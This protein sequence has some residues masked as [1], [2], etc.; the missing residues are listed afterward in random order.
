[1]ALTGDPTQADDLVQETL[2]RILTYIE[3]NTKIRDLRAYMFTVL[4]NVRLNQLAKSQR[5]G[6]A[7]SLSDT[8]LQI[9]GPASQEVHIECRDLAE[10][11]TQIPEEQRQ[12]VL[13][14][15]LEGLSYKRAAE[16]LDIP[17]GTVMSR[18]SRGREALRRLMSADA[19]AEVS[20]PMCVH[21]S[22]ASIASDHRTTRRVKRRNMH[23]SG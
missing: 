2:Y 3:D 14:I 21:Y 10:A 12:I 22:G 15:G 9:P 19:S 1:M 7:V 11:L 6:V 4:H 18:L 23:V 5:E 16:L 8:S 20:A 13:L 17:I